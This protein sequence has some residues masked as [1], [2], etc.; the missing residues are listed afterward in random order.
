MGLK[1]EAE[2]VNG[3]LLTRAKRIFWS[4]LQSSN[5]LNVG[6]VYTSSDSQSN[7]M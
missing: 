2:I 7:G 1:K 3:T 5:S 6:N 4:A